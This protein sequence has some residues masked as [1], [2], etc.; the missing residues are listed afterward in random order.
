[1]WNA[2]IPALLEAGFRCVTYDRRGHGHS[3]RPGRGYDTDSLADDL[4]AVLSHLDAS[5][6]VLAGHSLGAQEVVRY[7]SRHGTGRVTGAVL[8]APIS[9]VLLRGPD[10]PDGIDES[11]FQ[12]SREAMRTDIGAFVAATSA[13]DYFGADHEASAG[14]ADWTNRQI[15]DTPLRVLLEN[16]ARHDPG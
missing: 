5:A 16:P 15:I 2:Q 11:N 3:D 4:A 12:A 7:L 14:L 6:A 10:N 9:P 8:S 13:S 1:M